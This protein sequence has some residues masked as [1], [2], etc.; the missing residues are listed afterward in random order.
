MERQ[1]GWSELA[2]TGDGPHLWRG[3]S[4]GRKEGTWRRTTCLRRVAVWKDR[5]GGA[6]ALTRYRWRRTNRERGEGKGL[7]RVVRVEGPRRWRDCSDRIQVEEEGP[8]RPQISVELQVVQTTFSAEL[9]VE[10]ARF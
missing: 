3:P 10:A 4:K 8:G 2:K 7:R 5:A 1:G 6:T 9:Q